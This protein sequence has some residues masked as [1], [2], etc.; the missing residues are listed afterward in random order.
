MEIKR[1]SGLTLMSA[2]FASGLMACT[3]AP[4]TDLEATHVDYPKGSGTAYPD[5]SVQAVENA[6]PLTL[7]EAEALVGTSPLMCLVNWSAPDGPM[8]P[9]PS[10]IPAEATKMRDWARIVSPFGGDLPGDCTEDRAA[11]GYVDSGGRWVLMRSA[12][13]GAMPS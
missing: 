9:P 5:C 8:I 10:R 3:A 1:R 12:E 7:A 13:C 4:P 6:P 2:L 11:S